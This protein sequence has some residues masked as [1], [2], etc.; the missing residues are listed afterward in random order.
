MQSI[1]LLMSTMSHEEAIEREAPACNLMTRL[2]DKAL[3]LRSEYVM[4]T[5]FLWLCRHLASCW[6]APPLLTYFFLLL[7]S[8][9]GSAAVLSIAH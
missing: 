3:R 7:S 2:A 6:C 4:L 8:A 5:Q 9:E 1:D